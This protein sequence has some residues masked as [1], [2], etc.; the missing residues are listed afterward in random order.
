VIDS[1]AVV[2]AADGISDFDALHGGKRNEDVRLMP[3][4]YWRTTAWI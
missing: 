2:L 1:E 3:L 4:I